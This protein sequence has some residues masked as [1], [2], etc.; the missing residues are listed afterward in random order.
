MEIQVSGAGW[1]E[2]KGRRLRCALGKCG[3]S[4]AK[5][6]GDGCTPVG[7][8]ALRRGFY[9]PDRLPRPATALPL[10]ALTQ[11]HGWCDD[12]G[13]PDY[14]TQ[15][16][17]PHP[18]RCE[19]MWREDAVYDVVVVLGHNDDPPVAGLG[20]AIFLHVARPDW[21]G[22]EGCVALALPDLLELLADC[23]PGDR[24]TVVQAAE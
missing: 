11:A 10:E 4:I 20:S 3:L 14:N 12:P 8:F 16:T 24:L 18:A 5:R 19:T 22:T 7:S 23:R 6:E 21:S 13:H 2:W 9:R 17:L 15:V 1:L